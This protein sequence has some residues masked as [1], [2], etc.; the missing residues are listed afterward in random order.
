MYPY[1]VIV[2]LSMRSLQV[3]TVTLCGMSSNS[4]S[5]PDLLAWR[6]KGLL[7]YWPTLIILAR[8]SPLQHPAF[9]IQ[10]SSCGWHQT[11]QRC[12][13]I[14]YRS[15][16]HQKSVDE[17]IF[18]IKWDLS[19]TEMSRRPLRHVSCFMFH[20]LL[21]DMILTNQLEFGCRTWS[22]LEQQKK[23]PVHICCLACDDCCFNRR[24]KCTCIGPLLISTT[25]KMPRE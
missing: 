22:F 17:S 14:Q 13:L 8:I 25:A 4:S 11:F 16:A 2:S 10:H 23:V 1:Q 20:L 21:L 7:P 12:I 18:C 24:D 9:S 19:T 15:Y 6:Y 5:I 3:P